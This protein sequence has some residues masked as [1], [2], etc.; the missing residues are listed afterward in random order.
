MPPF[1]WPTDLQTREREI[2]GDAP[3]IAGARVFFRDNPAAGSFIVDECFRVTAA[4]DWRVEATTA[5]CETSAPAERFVLCPEGWTE[6]PLM[7]AASV[8]HGLS[9]SDRLVA[10]EQD[11]ADPDYQAA[12]GTWRGAMRL[13][14]DRWGP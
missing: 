4:D 7:P 13:W 10:R 1:D 9:E 2:T 14:L 12:L 8:R 6:P 3:F 5:G 11:A